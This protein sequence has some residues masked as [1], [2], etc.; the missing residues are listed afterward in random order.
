MDEE[1]SDVEITI[2]TAKYANEIT[3]LIDDGGKCF[4]SDYPDYD[5]VKETCCLGKII[6][7]YFLL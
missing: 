5:V 2:T 3:W 6:T 1:C 4:G 7:I